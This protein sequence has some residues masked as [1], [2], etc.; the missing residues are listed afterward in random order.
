MVA[1][2]HENI[3]EELGAT[4][5]HLELHGATSLEGR[6]AADDQG[7][8]VSTQ[9]RVGIWRVGICVASGSQDGAALNAGF[10]RWFCC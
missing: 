2:G 9:F 4:V 8:I 5:V 6:P 7:K 10:Y 1:H 3:K